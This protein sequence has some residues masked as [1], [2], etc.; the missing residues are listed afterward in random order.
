MTN[1]PAALYVGDGRAQVVEVAAP[2]ECGAYQSGARLQSWQ[3][4]R[5]WW[6]NQDLDVAFLLSVMKSGS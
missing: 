2:S 4:G 5:W 3:R 1:V 6:V